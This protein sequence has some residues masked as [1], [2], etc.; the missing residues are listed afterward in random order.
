[1][2]AEEIKRLL[3]RYYNAE[4]SEDEEIELRRFFNQ[5]DVPVDL[6]DE[7]EIFIYYDKLSD[8][9]GPS[10]DFER[11]IIASIDR[12]EDLKT[13]KSGFRRIFFTMPEL[14]PVL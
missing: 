6:S 10:A 1:M 12:L 13:K 5:D 11:K 4:T 9:Q 3:E 2:N 14:Q 8:I 7:K